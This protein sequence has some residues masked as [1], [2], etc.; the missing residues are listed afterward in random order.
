MGLVQ[1][2][3]SAGALGVVLAACSPSGPVPGDEAKTGEWIKSELLKVESQGPMGE[4]FAALRTKEPEIYAQLVDAATRTA[5]SGG[6]P[7]EAGAAVRPVY[8]ARFVELQKTAADTDINEMIAL[9]GDQMEAAMA[10]D[11][12]L[13]IKLGNGQADE[14]MGQFP[15]E[16][17]D[18][19][20]SIMARVLRAGP[21][22]A[23]AATVEEV[24]AWVAKFAQENPGALEGL[25]AMSNPAASAEEATLV[26]KANVALSEALAKEDPATSAKIFRAILQQG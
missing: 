3:L 20:M 6:S 8:L 21:G 25:A 5:A 1:R 18:K 19:E 2:L 13:C 7:F 15:A 10:I 9:S 4:V 24:D 14:R 12:Q 16:L 26:C 17:R 23:P 22:T 11:P